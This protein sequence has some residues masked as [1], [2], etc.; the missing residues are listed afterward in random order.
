[1]ATWINRSGSNEPR[2]GTTSH[3]YTFTAATSGSLLVGIAMGPTTETWS[4]GW[5]EQLQPLGNTE[6]SVATKTATAGES[7]V[8][9]THNGSN[10]QIY[11]V[12]YEFASGS[13]WV[14][15]I[16]AS[17]TSPTAA[18]PT[19]T[20]L[21]GTAVT[22][23]YAACGAKGAAQT[24]VESA[25]W[26]VTEDVDLNVAQASTDGCWYGIAYEDGVTATSR[27]TTPTLAN[28]TTSAI[29]GP[30]LERVT[31]AI[32]PVAGD[33]TAPSVPTNFQTTAIGSTTADFSWT[34]STD[35]VGVTGYEIQIIGP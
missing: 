22:V 23:F 17:A 13:T 14:N 35:A 3:T 26:T 9:L 4:A 18:Q 32:S 30:T 5:T 31:F 1:M 25:T 28:T 7:S 33:T 12:I 16:G 24:T 8:T 10:E 27:T 21:P 11:I 15:G 6:V 2:N 20:G 29:V 19:V 34:A